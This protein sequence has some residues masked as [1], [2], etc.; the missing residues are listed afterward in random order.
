MKHLSYILIFFFILSC[1]DSKI[2]PPARH[3]NIPQNSIWAG[4]PDGGSWIFCNKFKNEK[5]YCYVY[6]ENTGLCWSKGNYLL[7]EYSWDKKKNKPIYYDLKFSIN[8]LKYESYDGCIIK[9]QDP[10]ILVP[11]G[12]IDYPFGNGHGKIC[13]Y[14]L[15]DEILEKEY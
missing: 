3:P 12:K 1:K 7:K 15:G 2:I 8:K 14:K 5:Y 6:N 10:Y 4:G 11:D 13:I 9:L